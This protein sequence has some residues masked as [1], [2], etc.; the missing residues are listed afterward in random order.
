MCDAATTLANKLMVEA[1]TG[2]ADTMSAKDF[3]GLHYLSK[4]S[5]KGLPPE[6]SK[7]PSFIDPTKD[8]PPNIY[9]CN[10]ECDGNNGEDAVKNLN[11]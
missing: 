7:R 4:D 11:Y 2:Q 5:M 10:M 9:T 3:L 1:A 6:L 8:G